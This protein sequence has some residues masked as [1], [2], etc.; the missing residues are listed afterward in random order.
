[1]QT[2]IL[3][4]NSADIDTASMQ[5]AAALIRAGELVAFPTETVYGLG[6]DALRPE[7][8]G[9]I[10][11]AKGRPS[12]NPLIVHIADFRQL[13]RIAG[14]LPRQAKI[15]S[16]AFWPGPLTMIVWKNESVPFETTGGLNT[17]AVRMPKSSGGASADRGKRLSDRCAKRKY[18]RKTKSD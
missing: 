8:S 15:L 11:Q 16:D 9:K 1:M 2:K 4:I 7:A 18:F 12:D 10:Y 14:E 13:A 3:K 5:E 17:V 6:A